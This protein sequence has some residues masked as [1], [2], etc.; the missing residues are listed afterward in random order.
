MRRPTIWFGRLLTDLDTRQGRATSYLL[1][2]LNIGFLLLYVIGTYSVS[3]PYQ[4]QLI[5]IEFGLA[6]LFLFEYLSR[7]DY[8]DDPVAEAL[9]P[10]SI[11]DLLAI[12]PAL[13]IVVVPAV[14][15]LA[16]FRS[17]QVL[18]VLR[19]IR[20]G[21]E[22]ERFFTYDLTTR[23]VTIAELLVLIFIIVNLH[24]GVIYG[25]ESGSNPNLDTYGEALYYSVVA[26]TTTGFGNSVP[27]TAAGKA[28]TA[29]GL[30][31]AVTL[32]PWLV[33]RARTNS[34]PAV[35]CDRCGAEITT[36]EANY[37]WRC[38]DDL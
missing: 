20:I 14:G 25:L 19:F 4:P 36:G 11:A 30:I 24:A 38:G 27:I 26:L 8:A 35:S 17:V 18:R 1:Y 32:I 6:V 33:I 31:A 34:E 9:D 22:N 23:Q 7:I 21:L 16:F 10:Y 3:D 5:A 37:C 29:V 13:L 28:A 15:Q 12:L 2:A